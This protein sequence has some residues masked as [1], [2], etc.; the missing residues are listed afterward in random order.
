MIASKLD[1]KFRSSS[2]GAAIHA[3]GGPVCH[4]SHGRRE[5]ENQCEKYQDED[6]KDQYRGQ[7][8]IHRRLHFCGC[9]SWIFFFFK[10]VYSKKFI[11]VYPYFDIYF[12]PLFI[13]NCIH[14]PLRPC[15]WV[16]SFEPI[17]RQKH[18]R[19]R[20]QP[21]ADLFRCPLRCYF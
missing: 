8:R 14:T 10:Y 5:R 15:R 16:A 4:S 9:H 6:G 2:P 7:R 20:S 13:K 11:F 1:A 21:Q 17:S 19:E 3:I 12:S 18:P